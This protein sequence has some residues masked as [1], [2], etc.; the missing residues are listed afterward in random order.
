MTKLV[1]ALTRVVIPSV[2]AGF[3]TVGC[4]GRTP[5]PESKTSSNTV[6]L[7]AAVVSRLPQV[8]VRG[9]L[10]ISEV[11]LTD[12]PFASDPAVQQLHAIIPAPERLIRH[13]VAERYHIPVATTEELTRCTARVDPSRRPDWCRDSPLLTIATF[14]LPRAGGAFMPGTMAS[15]PG[16]TRIHGLYTTRLVLT[17]LNGG[18]GAPELVL[19]A[20]ARRVDGRWQLLEFISLL[21]VD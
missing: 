6:G 13:R 9:R 16:A 1:H 5:N 10:V 11:V 19:D 4:A 7:Y 14:G 17:Y 3:T 15:N 20:I 2:L 18:P 12:S 8:L 21:S